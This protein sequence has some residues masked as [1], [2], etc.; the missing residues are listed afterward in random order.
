MPLDLPLAELPEMDAMFFVRV[1]SRI[2]HI[3]AAIILGGGLFYIRS[4]LSHAGAD[5][6]FADRRAA[7]AR[8][9]GIMSLLL[10]ASGLFNLFAII[11]DAR[12]AGEKLPA[13]YHALFGVKFLLGLLVM[14]IAAILAGRTQLADRFRM[15]MRRWLNVAWG[16]VIAIVVIGALLRMM[17]G[18]TPADDRPDP[19]VA[20]AFRG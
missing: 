14:F 7:W 18:R 5:A 9:V 8:W 17:H 10:L 15:N 12:D 1:V 20:E 13:A 16:A 6:C 11:R 19:P 4:I 2:L 3:L